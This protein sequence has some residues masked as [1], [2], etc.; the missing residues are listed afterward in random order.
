MKLIIWA[1]VIYLLYKL[2]FE[3][4][5]PVSKATSQMRNTIKQ[6][7]EQQRANGQSQNQYGQ[8]TQNPQQQSNTANTKAGDYIDFEEIKNS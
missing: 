2:I 8:S 4:V 7:Q 1:I 3:F 6:M 5:M